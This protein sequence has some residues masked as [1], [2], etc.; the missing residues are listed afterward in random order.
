MSETDKIRERYAKRRHINYSDREILFAQ[1]MTEE[2]ERIYKR[3]LESRFKNLNEIRLLEVGAGAGA[4]ISFFKHL[5]VNPHFIFANEILE[6][7]LIAL[8]SNHPD[9]NVIP[10]NAL[11]IAVPEK[12][13][14]VFQSAVFT[15]ILDDSFRITL[16]Q[17]MMELTHGGGIILWYDFAFNNPRN[18][19]VKK[20]T[21]QE[22][23]RLFYKASS[24]RF[25]HVTLAPPIGRRVGKLY[26]FFNLFPFLRT[27]IIAEIKLT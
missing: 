12:F 9:I 18:P 13:D 25:H 8:K 11:D 14:V 10:G 7:R 17:K 2:R 1:Y 20:V 3:I 23:R 19:D 22:V 15:S 4:N 21:K 16:A 6:D 27:H 26:P 24:M 5:G